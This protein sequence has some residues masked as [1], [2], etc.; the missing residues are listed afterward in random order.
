METASPA[1]SPSVV[2]KILMIQKRRVTSGT[3]LRVSSMADTLPKK[4]EAP[5]PPPVNGPSQ[6]LIGPVP[7]P[8]RANWR[9]PVSRRNHRARQRRS[10]H[11]PTRLTAT[12]DHDHDHDTGE[13]GHPARPR[14]R[15]PV[16]GLSLT[17][18][19]GLFPSNTGIGAGLK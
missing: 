7:N 18:A 10:G 6:R 13:P 2:A 14:L 11:D 5:R 19:S 1:V 17:P 12:C 8:E 3:L 16:Y 9:S 15:P 4:Q